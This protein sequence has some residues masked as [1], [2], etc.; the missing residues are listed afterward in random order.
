M[1]E[2][3]LHIKLG[4]TLILLF[5]F[6]WG[7]ANMIS[8][9][10]NESIFKIAVNKNGI[11]KIDYQLLS[12]LGIDPA[13]INPRS[14]KI[15]GQPGGM[16]AQQNTP[17]IP[18][19]KEVAI[20]VAGEEDE[21]FNTNDYVLFWGEGPDLHYYDST[22]QIF[23]I[24]RN[25]YA[26]QNFYFLKIDGEEGQRVQLQN[27]A[28]QNVPEITWF[29]NY[30]HHET[31]QLN[32]LGSGRYWLG[33]S[34]SDQTTRTFTFPVENV[35]TN[36]E[37]KL[38]ASAASLANSSATLR[39]TFN[40]QPIGEMKTPPLES[41]IYSDKAALKREVFSFKPILSDSWKF[42]ADWI[43]DD[44][45]EYGHLD[46]LTI[47]Y[48]QKLIYSGEQ[49]FFRALQSTKHYFSKYKL[50]TSR[51]VWV[52]D[53][54]KP[55]MP[56]AIKSKPSNTGIEF[57][58]FSAFLKSYIAF[59][60]DKVSTP[61]I[62][63]QMVN[64]NL[65]GQLVPDLL[66]VA[67]EQFLSEAHRLA[68]HRQSHD[69][70]ETAVVSPQQIYNE[71]SS[72][73]QDITAIRNFVR[74]LY[75]KDPVKLKYLLLFGDASYDYLKANSEGNT[76][77]VPTYQSQNSTH[78]IFSHA[79]DDY[80][81]FMDI[82]EGQWPERN[83]N[84]GKTHD[85]EIG[86]GRLP[87]TNLQEAKLVVDKLIRYDQ[88]VSMGN[89][90]TKVTFVADDGD[91]N[92]HQLRSDFLADYIE[93]NMP[94]MTPE[95]LYIDAYPQTNVSGS[96]VSLA[97]RARLSQLVEEGTLIVDYIGHGGETAWAS[98]S[99]LLLNTI[100]EMRNFD[101]LPL[102][103]T[104]TC[105]FGRFDD[106][107]RQSGAELAIL[108]P[109]GGAVGLFTTTRPVFANTNFDLSFAFYKSLSE[110]KYNRL[111]D[112]FRTTKNGSV[113]G[114]VNRNFTL[115]GDP[116]LAL[117]LPELQVNI[118]TI[119][120]LPAANPSP[121]SSFREIMIQGNINHNGIIQSDFNGEVNITL[122]DQPQNKATLGDGDNQPM[123][124]KS[125]DKV[126]FKGLAKAEK[127]KFTYKMIIPEI[128][129][130]NQPGKFVLYASDR[131]QNL[132]AKGYLNIESGIQC[133]ECKDDTPPKIEILIDNENFQPGQKV[134][135]N[136]LLIVNL[137]DNSG[138]NI[139]PKKGHDIVL[140]LDESDTI[141]LN[142]YYQPVLDTAHKGKI[143]FELPELTK[144]KHQIKI[145][146]SDLFYN[147]AKAETYF[148]LGENQ[149]DAIQS[150]SFGPN[151]T[152][153]EVFFHF[154]LNNPDPLLNAKILIFS[155][156]GELMDQ[157]Q[158]EI[159]TIGEEDFS[160]HLN[161]DDIK[162]SPLMSGIYILHFHIYNSSSQLL[163]K[164]RG[165]LIINR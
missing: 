115:L 147:R 67:P 135:A 23:R 148:I 80:F 53:V 48:P 61:E 96:K 7:E 143:I 91:Q 113:Q 103:I 17:E 165:K 149:P 118:A 73:R 81:G 150:F 126:L 22:Y 155:S 133:S 11:Y 100:Y 65:L 90:R 39:Y 128:N 9:L 58:A 84:I 92:K 123:M 130:L 141:V 161:I 134:S 98:E 69:G 44:R 24:E 47:N 131:D 159:N 63:E 163:G 31:D 137:Q 108:Q 87:V 142:H 164:R 70:L 64:Q 89:W 45:G 72:G 66:I 160:L 136:P 82:N 153:Q 51:V 151:P 55:G 124:Y 27:V 41:T 32:L 154:S 10:A 112:L 129:E 93:N 20:W 158:A 42:E 33:E 138:I 125:R 139:A 28:D 85:L 145:A 13:T 21:I 1:T 15:F 36:T 38:L 104:A 109:G 6:N 156:K 34:F 152:D 162:G 30:Q 4:L 102:F 26:R 105:E 25:L 107:R 95:K 3:N 78:N 144:G 59:E 16:L 75:L 86:I 40:G 62:V 37:A 5:N 35:I 43:V 122:Y 50:T 99:L 146:A 83:Q 140:Y 88:Q 127:G 119:N 56:V 12:S 57:V 117:A 46:F 94:S 74:W 71:F 101:K 132:D 19:I 110:Q 49:L 116:S 77:F 114:V 97:G 52:W 79:S 121:L 68:K 8:P 120:D 29:N 157:L 54:T 18:R 60:P 106:Y 14:I 2:K 76:N 111:G